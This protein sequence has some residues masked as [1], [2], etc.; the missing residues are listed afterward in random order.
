MD[1]TRSFTTLAFADELAAEPQRL[2]AYA[3]TFGGADDATLVVYARGLDPAA[4]AAQLEEAVRLAGVDGEDAADVL[5]FA[6]GADLSHEWPLQEKLDAVYSD[7]T[8]GEPFCWTTRF[9]TGQLDGLRRLFEAEGGEADV[10]PRSFLLVTYDSCRYDVLCDART[11]V[12]DSYAPIVR[13]QSPANYT[14]AAHQSFFVGILPNATGSDPYHNRF[15]KQLW[16]LTAVGE[17]LRKAYAT[18]ASD[19]NLVAGFRARGHQTVGAGAMNWFKQ[20]SL[21]SSFEHFAFTGTDARAQI[22]FVR[23]HLDP[24]R[25]FFGFVNFGETHDPFHY[26]GKQGA[27]EAIVQARA[28]TWPPAETG[29]AGRDHPAYAHQVEAAEFLDAQLPRLFD[30][31]PGETVVVLCG[32]HGEC[33]G[34]DGYYGHGVNHEKVLE[35]PLAIFRLDREPL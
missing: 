22:D 3:R 28:M 35:V 23:G 13:A 15:T 21:T 9:G 5:L 6:P 25:P 20:T 4:A 29:P 16:K 7:R 27:C 11:P 24:A 19:Y 12:L 32:D 1:A 34:E 18:V 2:A 33:F 10:A 30:G 31:L 17:D 8:L 14:Y 26:E